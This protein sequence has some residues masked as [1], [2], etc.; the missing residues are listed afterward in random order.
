MA[1]YTLNP[2]RSILDILWYELTLPE[3]GPILDKNKYTIPDDDQVPVFR[4][5]IIPVQQQIIYNNQFVSNNESLPYLVYDHDFSN[6]GDVDWWICKER[7][8]FTIYATEY[9][10]ILQIQQ[11]MIDLFRRFDDS[12]RDL[13][14]YIN[15]RIADADLDNPELTF[16][17]SSANKERFEE[18]SDSFTYHYFNLDQ[19][20][21]PDPASS[22]GGKMA[23]RIAIDFAYSRKVEHNG[24]FA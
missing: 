17:K 22:E 24:R 18:I 16:P 12:A 23:G 14:R 13:N 1:D 21:E 11:L 10:K 3:N 6:Y 2:I 4:F 9:S 15:K 8:T 19:L 20:V 5:P 7:L